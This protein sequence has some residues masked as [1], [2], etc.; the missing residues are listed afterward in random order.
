MLVRILRLRVDSA[1]HE[2]I[3]NA[4]TPAERDKFLRALNDPSSELA[5]QLLASEEL[6]KEQVEPWW[7]APLAPTSEEPDS[8]TDGAAPRIR[9]TKP[10]I[11]SLPEALMKRSSDASVN[12]PLLLYNIC[13]VW[14]VSTYR[15]LLTTPDVQTQHSIRVRYPSFCHSMYFFSLLT[16]VHV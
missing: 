1:S 10:T 9:R 5:H 4:L 14:C 7:E 12:G 3:W 15:P 16:P 11:M 13:A 6:E 8:L 2:E